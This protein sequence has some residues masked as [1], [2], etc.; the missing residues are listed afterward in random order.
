MLGNRSDIAWMEA[1]LGDSALRVANFC[2][3]LH[4]VA[5]DESALGRVTP[6]VAAFADTE[7]LEAHAK[8][9]RLRGARK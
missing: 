1:R 6:Y 3:H 4:V 8:S 2:K 9:V 7:G 5:L